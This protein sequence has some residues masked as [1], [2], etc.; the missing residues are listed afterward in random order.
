MARFRLEPVLKLRKHHEEWRKRELSSALT[1]ENQ[2]KETAVRYA[3][4][5]QEQ[6]QQVRQQQRAGLLDIRTL[7][8]E[9][10]YIG[11]LDREI[12]SQFRKVALAE[13]QTAGRRTKLAEAMT[14]RKALE[15][16]RERAAEAER[17]RQAREETVA[18]DEVGVRLH[19]SGRGRPEI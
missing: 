13:H 7:I 8:D 1:V 14:A 16:L 12:Q 6:T 2:E 19:T 11:L 15:V 18:L 3:R 17:A 4:M 9:K 5:R 10:A